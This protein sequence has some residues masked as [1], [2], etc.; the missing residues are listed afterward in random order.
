M[1]NSIKLKFAYEGTDFTRTYQLDDVATE[2]LPNVKTKVQAVNAKLAAAKANPAADF[3]NTKLMLSFVS[4]D[5]VN[6][7]SS[8]D[9]PTAT[10]YFTAITEATIVQES[11]TKI[12]LFE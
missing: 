1:S 6:H 4:D 5:F 7:P 12:P 10:G 2:A 8:S 9:F 3:Y 11:V